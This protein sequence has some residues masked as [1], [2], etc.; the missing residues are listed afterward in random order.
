[1]QVSDPVILMDLD[2]TLYAYGPCNE[3]GLAAAYHVARQVC[4]TVEQACFLAL[5]DEVRGHWARELPGNAS[6]HNRVL[7]FKAMVE[8]WVDA[9]HIDGFDA[10]L[11]LDLDRAY[12]EA[13]LGSI[14]GGP[15]M[16]SVL[17]TLSLRYRLALVTNQVAETQLKKIRALGIT[18]FFATIVTSEEAGT[19]KPGPGIY[20]EA[21]AR[22]GS[23]AEA[24]C[25]VGDSVADIA[26]AR[27]CGI[28]TIHTIE[29]TGNTQQD[30]AAD[31]TIQ[32]LID[33]LDILPH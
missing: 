12:W 9:G 27:S 8:R 29:F 14:Q 3:A 18:G 5:H 15:D 2:D 23:T 30:V 7:F 22:L 1:V 11:V 33:V 21:L 19:E 24:A 28:Q 32:R 13:F 16:M 10:G 4:R 25:M 20:L 6:S 31:H 26:G 17:T